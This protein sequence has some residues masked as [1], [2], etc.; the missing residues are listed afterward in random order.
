M[1]VHQGALPAAKV[2]WRSHGL[3]FLLA[4][5]PGIF[6]HFLRELSNPRF[7]LGG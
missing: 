7:G 6:N 5:N 3:L 2:G 4:M 1:T